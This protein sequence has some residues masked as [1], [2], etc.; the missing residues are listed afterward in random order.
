[1]FCP[2]NCELNRRL[3]VKIYLSRCLFQRKKSII[4]L[5]LCYTNVML[6]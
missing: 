6:H 4:I 5:F 3:N 2:A 1:M